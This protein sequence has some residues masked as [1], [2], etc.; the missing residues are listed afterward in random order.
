MSLDYTAYDSKR[1]GRI[2]VLIGAICL[3]FASVWAYV[4]FAQRPRVADGAIVTVTG[5]PIHTELRQGGTMAQGYGGGVQKSDEELVWVQFRMQNL[6]KD[7]PLYATAQRATLT[8]TDGRQLFATAEMPTE[9]AHARAALPALNTVHG[10]LVPEGVTLAPGGGT[11]GLALFAFPITS[12]QWKQRRL[13]SMDVDFQWQR[14]LAM[15]EP[16][17][18][19]SEMLPV[20]RK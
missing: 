8:F 2:I 5:I 10:T 9:I 17:P 7:V 4:F 15:Q 13:F 20:I 11:S 3:L 18:P 14:P 16:D 1:S 6:T 12:E 19:V